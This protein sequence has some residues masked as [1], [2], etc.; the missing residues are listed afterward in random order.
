[1]VRS[2]SL[3]PFLRP[4]GVARDEHETVVAGELA[5][6]RPHPKLDAGARPTAYS[7]HRA[8]LF[9]IVQDRHD[10]RYSGIPEIWQQ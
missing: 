1:M 10:L 5:F 7:N 9:L 4:N 3:L 6:G 2:H 8:H